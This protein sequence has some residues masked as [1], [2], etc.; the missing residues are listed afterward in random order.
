MGCSCVATGCRLTHKDDV[1]LLGF[2]KDP[3]LRKK[4]ADQVRRTK[5][6]WELTWHSVLCSKH[7]DDWCLRMRAS[8]WTPVQCYTKCNL[9][10]QHCWRGRYLQ[11]NPSHR[12][13]KISKWEMWEIEVKL[14]ISVSKSLALG[15]FSLVTINAVQIID[16]AKWLMWTLK[17][18]L[19]VMMPQFNLL[20]NKEKWYISR[21][22]T[23]FI[24]MH[25]PTKQPHP[26]RVCGQW[27]SQWHWV[28]WRLSVS[29]LFIYLF[30]YW[31]YSW[32]LMFF[33]A[34][35]IK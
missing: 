28:L 3:L 17:S 24:S 26:L 1:S 15:F 18:S 33:P 12:E 30:I 34:R 32:C 8:C 14:A 27:H 7:F 35:W 19:Q 6:K 31:T 21:N 9:K 5:D 11:W 20:N 23:E 16:A 22:N 25:D 29:K 10:S 4:W 2:A 13:E